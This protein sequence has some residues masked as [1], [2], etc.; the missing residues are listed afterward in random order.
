MIMSN[1]GFN[2]VKS[3]ALLCLP[4]LLA[5][6]LSGAAMHGPQVAPEEK[7]T[8]IIVDI[9]GTAE[10]VHCADLDGDGLKDLIVLSSF[11]EPFRKTPLFSIF[12]QN[13]D[14]GFEPADIP[15]ETLSG[16]FLGDA[17]NFTSDPGEELVLLS[18]DSGSLLRFDEQRKVDIVERAFPLTSLFH[19][20]AHQ[21]PHLLEFSVDCDGNGFD[22][23]IAPTPRGYAVLLS[24]GDGGFEEPLYLAGTSSWSVQ[25][26]D[27]A[28]FS[29]MTLTS[30]LYALPYT[31]SDPLLVSVIDGKLLAHRFL[32]RERGFLRL[33]SRRADF[34]SFAS[35]AKAG[36]IEYAGIVFSDRQTPESP[37][38]V[39]SIREGRPG[40]LAELKTTHTIFRFKVNKKLKSVEAGPLQRIVTDGVASA[41]IFSDL[42]ADGHQDLIFMYVKTSILTKILEFLLDR[43]VVTCQAHLFLPDQ[44]R[45]TF[46][47]DWSDDV[48]MPTKN[49]RLVGTEGLILFNG[50]Y[51]G[52]GR[53]DMAVFDYDRLLFRR[54]ERDEGLFSD[55]E[56][57]FN[58]RPFYQIG[59]PFPGPLFSE[60]IDG[61]DCPEIITLGGSIVRIVHVDP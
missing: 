30:K 44:G 41:P 5:A 33:E 3:L 12:F 6:T 50:D 14:R 47:P 21:A 36:S 61:D 2:I 17:G 54:G 27:N 46:A 23:F 58:D 15:R 49:L 22:D 24:R 7:P 60:N 13:G 4:A 48:S 20:T 11:G 26:S 9:E 28:M 8:D 59:S 19:A 57:S 31:P 39:R 55:G 34:G 38:F 40:I 1:M 56:I 29:L 51:T 16:V 25:F 43:V 42:N 37:Y 45:F 18:G 53:P 35:E 52:D 32:S 10:A